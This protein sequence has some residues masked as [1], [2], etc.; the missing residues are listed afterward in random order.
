MT[1]GNGQNRRKRAKS[2]HPTLSQD[3]RQSRRKGG[4]WS[5]QGGFVARYVTRSPS[6]L[7]RSPDGD[8]VA[9]PQKTARSRHPGETPYPRPPSAD[10][11]PLRGQIPAPPPAVPAIRSGS[12]RS[13]AAK[14]LTPRPPPSPPSGQATPPLLRGQ[15]PSPPLAVPAIRSGDTAPLERPD[16]VT[17]PCCPSHQIRRHRPS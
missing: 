1:G 16:P 12:A 8:F 17:T 2:G 14:T 4:D 3:W 15:I 7:L 13:P 11:A 9:I 10:T 6:A 5:F